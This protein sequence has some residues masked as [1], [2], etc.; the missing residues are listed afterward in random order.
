V[1]NSVSV[2]NSQN[3]VTVSPAAGSVFFRLVN[4]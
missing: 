3:Q 2:T 4:P 1:T